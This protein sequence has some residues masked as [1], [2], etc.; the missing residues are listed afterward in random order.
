LILA[1]PEPSI[2]V[3]YPLS[4]QKPMD[5]SISFQQILNASSNGVIAT[6]ATGTI[7]FANPQV[8][9][10][11]GIRAD[12]I[13]GAMVTAVLPCFGP[14]VLE[15]LRTG[16][17][18]LGRHSV[19]K[20]LSLAVSSTLLREQGRVKGAVCNF[21]ST[22]QFELPPHELDS[23]KNLN[24][25]LDAI[26][27]SSSDG[28]WVCDGQGKVININGASEKLNGV[29]AA[30]M[31]GRNV[32]EIMASGLF[33][34]SVTLE[35]LETGRQVS[36][37][38]HIGKTNRTLLVTGTPVFDEGAQIFLVVVNERDLTQLNAIREQLEQ[39]RM[40]TEKF[41]DELAELA[42]LELEKQK[43]IAENSNM[44]Q[45]LQV[46]L[47]LANLEVSNVLILGESGT[48]KGLLAKFMH[49][50]SKRHRQPFIQINCA[51]LPESLL[52]AELFGYEKGAFTGAREQGKA[53]LFELAQGGTLF[54]DEIGDLPLAVQ[55]KL[56]KYLD[57][58]EILRLG[59][60]KSKKI[61][62]AVIAATNRDLE[63]L[64]KTKQFRQDLLYRLN[65]FTLRI[66]PLRER[67]EDV[68][69]L[70]NH[71]L[72]KY[73][74]TYQ[75]KKRISP[76]ALEELQTYPFPGNVRELKSLLKRAILM[77]DKDLLDEF[78][79][80]GLGTRLGTKSGA[81]PREPGP[82]KLT[83]G[84]RELEREMIAKAMT[85]CNSTRELARHLGISQ[86]TVVRKLRKYGLGYRSIHK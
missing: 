46:A 78:L 40:V 36:V 27:R 22:A 69:E 49:K 9:S 31:I 18:H 52:E 65:T 61:D 63:S 71:F 16:I 29:K 20:S 54:L 24:R 62:C 48:G 79:L 21:Q 11:L 7:I 37:I 51:A 2:I 86:P 68:L 13:M 72:R 50:N 56:L 83:A 43:I 25:Q 35:V 73:N 19:G 8:E 14:A 59:G 82:T 23:Y 67:T 12:D 42:V 53:G 39:S 58:F 77:N 75:Q 5:D 38:Q 57:D 28:I 30:D 32:T 76:G 84:M 10:L 55:A 60:L 4:L 47:K 85:E 64:A 41:R 66:P 1:A 15:S 81:P 17:P 70:V 80:G 6:D 44:R 34:R 45:V 74:R 3:Y 26:F 33:D